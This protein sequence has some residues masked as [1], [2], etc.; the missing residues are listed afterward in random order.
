ML[1]VLIY[2]VLLVAVT[3]T[4]QNYVTRE[5][6]DCIC[7]ASTGCNINQGCNTYCGPYLISYA[8]WIETDQPGRT[9]NKNLYDDFTS[10]VKKKECAEET[11]QS[12]MKIWAKNCVKNKEINCNDVAR[13]HKT[14]RNGCNG[15]WFESTQYWRLFQDCYIL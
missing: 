10:C 5:C 15:T 6:F 3:V 4:G 13:I 9:G 2:E 8:Y 14:G 7:E 11:I 12:Y 1:K